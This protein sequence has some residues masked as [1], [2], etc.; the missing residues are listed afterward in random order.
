MLRL[1]LLTL[2]QRREVVLE[3]KDVKLYW[4][5]KPP[6]KPIR[7]WCKLAVVMRGWA[8]PRLRVRKGSQAASAAFQFRH[9]R[10]PFPELPCL[11]LTLFD[12]LRQLDSANGDCRVV[13]SFESQ[14]RPNPLFDSA[15]VLFDEIV[16]V[17]A[18]STFTRRG[19][20]PVSFISRTARCDAA[21]P[22]PFESQGVLR[23]T[24]RNGQSGLNQSVMIGNGF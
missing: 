19:S 18:R 12:L 15:V 22:L 9:R 6:L 13:E 7:L 1:V 5:V 23:A 8:L 21:S 3:N 4:G 11:E 20:S 10:F 24:T 14:H 16:Q 17:L 2:E